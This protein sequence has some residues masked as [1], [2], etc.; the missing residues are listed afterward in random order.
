MYLVTD[1]EVMPDGRQ[2]TAVWVTHW[3]QCSTESQHM[4]IG[5]LLTYSVCLSKIGAV[6]ET[7][8]NQLFP[9]CLC[10]ESCTS[11][12]VR[13]Y[14]RRHSDWHV[15]LPNIISPYCR[16]VEVLPDDVRAHCKAKV[17]VAESESLLQFQSVY[18]VASILVHSLK[19]LHGCHSMDFSD[20]N[21][22]IDAIGW[23]RVA[24]TEMSEI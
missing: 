23:V 10:R 15:N 1:T 12:P 6:C 5:T 4:G 7:P 8:G 20:T 19:P 24:A 13:I 14:L 3:C 22:V 18:S 11:E 2:H 9:C 21:H 16:V 17:Q